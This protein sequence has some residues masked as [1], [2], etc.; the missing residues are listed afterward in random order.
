MLKKTEMDELVTEDMKRFRVA[1]EETGGVFGGI[2]PV[3]R[4][5]EAF[6]G[7]LSA[8][9]AAA[10]VGLETGTFL[11]KISNNVS[12]QNLLGA[13]VLENGVIKTR[14]M[15]IGFSRCDYCVGFS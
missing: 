4:L 12:L 9:H 10:A 5:H 6:Q 3:Q 1:L 13:L 7:P 11:E 8:A 14:R 2:E 15:D